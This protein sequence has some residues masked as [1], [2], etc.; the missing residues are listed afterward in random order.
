MKWQSGEM[1]TTATHYLHQSCAVSVTWLFS[2]KTPKTGKKLVKSRPKVA[3]NHP[4]SDNGEKAY[5]ALNLRTRGEPN[6]FENSPKRRK[7]AESPILSFGFTLV[8]DLAQIAERSPP[9][10]EVR[11]SNPAIVPFYTVCIRE[12]KSVCV[13]EKERERE[14]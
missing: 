5:N 12:T 4:N 14:R 2:R 9:K 11:C 13:C 6:G 7:I 3:K 8:A 1:A 10:L